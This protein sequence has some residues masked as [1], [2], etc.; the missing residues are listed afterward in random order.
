MTSE[1]SF[2]GTNDSSTHHL[3][4]P[5]GDMIKDEFR[6]VKGTLSV[7]EGPGLGVEIDEGKLDH[8]NKMYLSGKYVPEPGLGRKQ[9]NL[10]H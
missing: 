7:H 5:S 9:M 6:T 1:R 8:Y 3:E 4:P 2:K 10:W